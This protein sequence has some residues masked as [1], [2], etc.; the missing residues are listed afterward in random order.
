MSD[1]VLQISNLS[2]ALPK[3]ADRSHAIEHISLSIQRGQTLCVVGESGSGKSVM[4][5]AVMGLLA[6]ELKADGGEILLQGE[7]LLKVPQTRL[8]ELRGQAMGMVFQEP[9][10]ALNPVMR[11]GDQVDELLA[12]HTDWSAEKRKAEVLRVF[13]GVK[14]PDPLRMYG[15]FPHQLSGGQRQRI[16]IAM[17]VILKPALLICDEPTTALDVTTQKEILKLISQLQAEQGCAVLFITHDMGVVAEIADDVLVMNQGRA[18]ESGTCEQVLKQ[19]RETYTQTLLAAVPSMTPPPPRPEAQGAAILK[20][21]AVT[22]TYVS[23]DWLG[24]GHETHAL[25]AASVAVRAG[26]TIGIVGESG[27]G[28]ST[29]ARCLIRLIDPTAG[30]IYW[31]DHEIATLSESQ[32]R[33]H[34]QVV[35]QDPNRS[36]NPRRTVGQSIVEGAINF[37]MSEDKARQLS[38]TL[39]Q[40]VRL[41]VESLSRY[42]TQFSGGQRQRLAIA[43]ALA[44]EPKVL[45]ADEAVSALDVSVQAQILTLLREIQARLGLGMLFI[46]HD[47]RVAAQLCDHVIVMHQGEIVEAGRTADLY[48]SP[49][50]AY[51]RKLF[52]AAPPAIF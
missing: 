24:R 31:A 52:E 18:V 19:A 44:C 37:G 1:T 20:G 34:V 5:T 48:A 2:V 11:C 26:E 7:A 47:L 13:E 43:R 38:E 21:A 9:M 4:A 12:T 49:Q 51:T 35:F 16:V 45:V 27:S 3:G 22:K 42:P 6:K 30:E 40:Q 39:M 14:L 15:S 28:K 46:T 25:K 32:L 33:S 50:H 10:T 41:P 29:L 8:R 17:A 36:L 23:R